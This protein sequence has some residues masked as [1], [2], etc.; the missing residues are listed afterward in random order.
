[1]TLQER[2]L[3]VSSMSDAD[4]IDHLKSLLAQTYIHTKE[5]CD[6]FKIPYPEYTFNEIEIALK[7]C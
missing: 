4:K 7:S 6:C 5:L 2:M 1:M 3:E